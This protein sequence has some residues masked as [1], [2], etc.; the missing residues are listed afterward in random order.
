MFNKI[1]IT[2]LLLIGSQLSAQN[3]L[4][5]LVGQ[6]AA[7]LQRISDDKTTIAQTFHADGQ[8]PYRVTFT[9]TVTD[10]KGKSNEEKYMFNLADV[11][12]NSVRWESSKKALTLNFRINR[13]QKFIQTF[14]NGAS[15][16]FTDDLSFLAKGI[17]NAR[18]LKT[19]FEQAI[20]LAVE[21]WEKDSDLHGKSD[22]E[23]ITLLRQLVGEVNIGSSARLLQRVGASGDQPDRL[24]L[25]VE[26]YNGKGLDKKEH[27]LFNLGDLRAN[28]IQMHIQGPKAYV[29]ASTERNIRWIM[30]EEEGKEV[31]YERA[32]R[33]YVSDTDQGQILSAVLLKLIPYGKEA[34]DKRLPKAQDAREGLQMLAKTQQKF[35]QGNSSYESELKPDCRCLLSQIE[36]NDKST[37]LR[38]YGFHFGDL[39]EKSVVLD[40]GS[41]IAQV[42]VS[43]RGRNNF[44]HVRKD[45]QQKSYGNQVVFLLPDAE[46]ARR[47]E[48]L[49][50][51]VIEK[52]QESP[53][54]RDFSWLKT[55]TENLG[56]SVSELS[57]KLE[58]QSGDPCKWKFTQTE[59]NDKKSIETVYEFN[60]YD[61][62]E[63][64][65]SIKV[66]GIKLLLE[67]KTQGNQK[68]ISRYV[69]GKPDYTSVVTLQLADLDEVKTAQVTLLEL[70]KSCKK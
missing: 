36:S 62:D 59:S 19:L 65:V 4:P 53:A 30:A 50:P 18:A 40:I 6:I 16:G 57:Q 1:T 69:N 68:I 10:A 47:F 15:N 5:A 31:S 39:N 8:K 9:R 70:L 26:E 44:V 46:H 61:L 37:E 60:V 25:T 32:V 29:E 42:K 24:K 7:E 11:D 21:A 38:E 45:G 28:N 20:P 34:L 43:T 52:C 56:K 23:L 3:S 22:A 58:L 51:F 33:F 49:L 2:V 64:A 27:F 13:N 41:K 14:K 63:R 54:A 35:N 12:K 48:H 17:D 66:S 67:L 55:A